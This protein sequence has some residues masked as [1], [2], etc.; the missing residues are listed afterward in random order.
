MY[1]AILDQQVQEVDRANAF[2]NL[3]VAVKFQPEPKQTKLIANL[4][5]GTPW[6]DRKRAAQRLGYMGCQE[7]LPELL[8]VLPVDPFWMVRYAIIQAVVMIGNPEAVPTL[9]DVALNDGFQI[10]RSYAAKAIEML[11]QR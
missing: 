4:S 5:P 9:Q 2:T 6:G 8:S 1:T 10:V 11:L 7:A 3:P